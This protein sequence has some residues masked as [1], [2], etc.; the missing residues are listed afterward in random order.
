MTDGLNCH[1]GEIMLL[2][3]NIVPC[4]TRESN[5]DRTVNVAMAAAHVAD[6]GLMGVPE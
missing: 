5:V 1:L 2:V 6:A 4:T 3:Q